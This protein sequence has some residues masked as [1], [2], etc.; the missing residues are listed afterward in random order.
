MVK[1][2]KNLN[3][4]IEIEGKINEK[5]TI[6]INEKN[7]IQN[8]DLSFTYLLSVDEG[9]VKIKIEANGFSGKQILGRN[10]C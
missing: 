6:T 10:N 8:S 2:I 7:A 5:A 4:R 9:D 3:K 1:Q